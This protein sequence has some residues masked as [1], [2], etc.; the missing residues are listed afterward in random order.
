MAKNQ[1]QRDAYVDDLIDHVQTYSN[2]RNRVPSPPTR[3]YGAHDD[4]ELISAEPREP[5]RERA[6]TPPWFE[7]RARDRDESPFQPENGIDVPALDSS[8]DVPEP[9]EKEKSRIEG[10]ALDALAYYAPYHFYSRNHW[11]IYIRD[12]GI[13]YLASR[14]LG[15]THLTPADNWALR[16]AHWFLYE[17]E[18]FHFQ[19]E[20]AASNFEALFH[21]QD[22]YYES[23]HDRRMAWI[24]EGMAN[25]R[26]HMHLK[27]HEDAQLTY[28]RI[29][30][31]NGFASNWM[32]TQPA[33]YRDF[34]QWCRSSST[35]KNGQTKI[36]ERLLDLPTG[37]KRSPFKIAPE[38]LQLFHWAEHSRVPLTRVHDSSVPWLKNARMFPKHLGIQVFVYTKE[39]PPAHIHVEFTDGS[40]PVKVEWP[41]LNP[42][43]GERSLTSNEKG[44]L[45]KYLKKHQSNVLNKLREVFSAPHLAAAI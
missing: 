5:E 8:V 6:P 21:V 29:S 3:I 19:A 14:F 28:S 38:V 36:A 31:F 17:H 44:D 40:A 11:G 42:C 2:P 25:A 37:Y 43:R 30:Q 22:A 39:H 41:S 24:E 9:D 4:E 23:F 13:A 33:G 34:D 35:F 16:C 18:Y 1:K 20:T 7:P 45:K 26:A 15:R 27:D 12:Y 10:Y 32:K